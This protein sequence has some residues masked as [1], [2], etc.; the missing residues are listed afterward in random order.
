MRT[1]TEFLT[2]KEARTLLGTWWINKVPTGMGMYKFGH[3]D[4]SDSFRL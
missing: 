3:V 1:V 2:T 4:I